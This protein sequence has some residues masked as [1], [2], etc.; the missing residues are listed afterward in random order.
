MTPTTADGMM[1]FVMKLVVS[2]VEPSDAVLGRAWSIAATLGQSDVFDALG[3]AVA[4]EIGAEFWTSDLRFHNA[5][6]GA[7]LSGIRFVA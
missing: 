2:R 4:E 6:A 5:A 3:Y 1:D 7:G